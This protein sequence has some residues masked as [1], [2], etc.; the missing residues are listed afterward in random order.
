MDL[1][2]ILIELTYDEIIGSR[3]VGFDNMSF[4]SRNVDVNSIFFAK[5]DSGNGTNGLGWGRNDVEENNI[6]SEGLA[7]TGGNEWSEG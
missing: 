1:E 7:S 6:V 3:K 5:S 4:D 2:N